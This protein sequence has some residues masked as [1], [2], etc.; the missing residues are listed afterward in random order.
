VVKKK[1]ITI[2][3]PN[4]QTDGR[5]E[6]QNNVISISRV[7]MADHCITS[8]GICPRV[9]SG[10][11]NNPSIFAFSHRAYGIMDARLTWLSAAHC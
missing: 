5:T 4:G 6:G 8:M 11:G 7:K 1:T 9:M 3:E 2:P 10:G